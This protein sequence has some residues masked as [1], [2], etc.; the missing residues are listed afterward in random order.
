MAPT[1]LPKGTYCPAKPG[2]VRGPCPMIN[3]LAN[4][5]YL[6]RDGRNVTA[7]ELVS[8]MHN[9]AGLSWPLATVFV[10]PIFFEHPTSGTLPPTNTSLWKTILHTIRHPGGWLFRFGMRR[11]RQRDPVSHKKC[12]DLDQLGLPGVIEHDISLTRR[13]YQQGDNITLQSDLVDALLAAG[14]SP[15]PTDGVQP[16]GNDTEAAR[17]VITAQDLAALRRRRIADQRAQNPGLEYGPMQHAFGCSE[18]A[19]L[20]G[21]LGNGKEVRRD[22]AAAFFKEERLPVEEGWRRRAWW[23]RLGFF[24][25]GRMTAMMK[26]LVGGL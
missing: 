1:E 17:G 9:V 8:A 24:G 12:I 7:G 21:I 14:L 20:L 11:K 23:N 16:N 22:Y 25:L 3:T 2:D 13:D 15:S 4:H 6:P 18:I 26:K 5:G 19:L 10:R